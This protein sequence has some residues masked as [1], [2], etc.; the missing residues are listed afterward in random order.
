MAVEDRSVDEGG[1]PAGLL[2]IFGLLLE[3]FP[4]L[5]DEIADGVDAFPRL[6]LDDAD[7]L[8]GFLGDLVV[9]FLGGFAGLDGLVL[10]LFARFLAARRGDQDADDEAFRR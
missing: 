5:F 8:L 6:F 7:A 2:L 1:E 10:D 4:L 9:A 3:F